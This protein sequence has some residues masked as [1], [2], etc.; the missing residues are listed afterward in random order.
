MGRETEFSFSLLQPEQSPRQ[1]LA[2]LCELQS[3][4]ENMAGGD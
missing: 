2:A 1:L 4:S 3:P